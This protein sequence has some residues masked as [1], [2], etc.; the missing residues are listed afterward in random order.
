MT[1]VKVSERS[2]AI[3]A[4]FALQVT[5]WACGPPFGGSRGSIALA[6]RRWPFS[7]GSMTSSCVRRGKRPSLEDTLSGRRTRG[8]PHDYVRLVGP[9]R[10]PEAV[11]GKRSQSRGYPD[12]RQ[13][14]AK[15]LRFGGPTRIRTWN[16]R[17]RLFR[18]FPDGADYLFTRRFGTCGCGTLKP[19]IKGTGSPQV[20]SA[21]SGGAPPAWLRVAIGRTVKVSL[22]S[23][24]SRPHLAVRRHLSMSPL[25]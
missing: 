13:A 24:R 19:V 5:S 9:A 20:V 10:G 1:I 7:C 25:L 4:V 16:Q 23:S 6:S 15:E 12:R 17:I 11:S 3:S 8:N 18:L 2:S 22:N 14:P 21:P